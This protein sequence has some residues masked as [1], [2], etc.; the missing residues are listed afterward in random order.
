M[1]ARLPILGTA[2]TAAKA[3][4]GVLVLLAT[5]GA[6]YLAASGNS[7]ASNAKPDL[8]VQVTPASQTV[9]RGQ[10]VAYT[11]SITPV[12]G[13]TGT[14]SLAASGL[15]SGASAGFSPTSL[16]ITSTATAT[17]G[18]TVSTTATTTL[19][20]ATFTITASSGKVSSS[21]SATLSVNAALS[22]S[23]MISASPSTVAMAPGATAVYSLQLSR[24][25]FPDAVSLSVYGGLPAGASA[26][27]SPNPVTGNAAT[28]Q[29]STPAST[30]DG[31]YT[32]YLVGTGRDAGG[33]QRSAYANVQLTLETSGKAFTISGNLTDLLSP[34]ASL[35][36]D[37]ALTNPNKK[38]ISIS[39]LTVTL[40]GVVRTQAAIAANKPCG[41][42]DYAIVQYTGP[43]PLTVTGSSTAKLSQL[44]A[45][46][47][48]FPHV[49]MRNTTSNQ[50]GCKGATLNL[51]YSGSGQGS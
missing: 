17:S 37:L 7:S 38:Q 23:L 29:I 36:L 34:G 32:L 31:S 8:T 20:N 24:Q 1:M 18:L 21:I 49:L 42:A 40:S 46:P 9:T 51:T 44:N 43:Y 48:A 4:L 10:S 14:V 41:L 33:Q 28:L 2:G 12:N 13:F 19:G 22:S 3:V 25:N 11:V 5:A 15:L 26:S 30:D 35:P 39:N 6:A 50:D 27:F 45:S 16:T 47:A